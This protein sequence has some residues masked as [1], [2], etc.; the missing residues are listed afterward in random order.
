MRT[1]PADDSAAIMTP[2][3]QPVLLREVLEF[4]APAPGGRYLDATFGGGGHTRA[5]LESAPGGHVVAFDRDPEAQPRAAVLAAE[6]P[7]QFELIDQDFGRL[8]ELAQGE[9]DGVLFDLGV[10]SFQL[11]DTARGAQGFG[12]SGR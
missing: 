2:G 1:A 9:F 6:F 11:D 3:H 4:M 12:S 10:S 8:G 5:L 7:G